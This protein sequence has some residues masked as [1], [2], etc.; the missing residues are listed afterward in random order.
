MTIT[1]GLLDKTFHLK[2]NK[3]TIKTNVK[4]S[5]IDYLMKISNLSNFS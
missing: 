1:L 3:I 4:I 2:D 5:D